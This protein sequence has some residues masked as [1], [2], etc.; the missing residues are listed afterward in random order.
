MLSTLVLA[1]NAIK[2]EGAIALA[3]GLKRNTGLK[4]L[5]LGRFCDIQDKGKAALRKA[6]DKRKGFKLDLR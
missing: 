6:V 3:E 2:D 4:E 5:G 1:N